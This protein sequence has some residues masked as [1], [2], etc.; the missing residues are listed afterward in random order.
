MDNNNVRIQKVISELGVMSRRKAEEAILNRRVTVNG[1][2][3]AIGMKVNPRKDIIAVDGENIS[4]GKK[5]TKYY[6]A[7]HKPRG[8]VTTLSDEMDRRCVAEL[9]ENA[10]AKVYPIGRLDRNTEGLLIFTNDGEFANMM[11]H[12]RYHVPKTYRVT[13]RPDVNDEQL[14]KLAQGVEIDGVM[15][16]PAEIKVLTKEPDRAVM[17]MSIT[18][19]RNRQIRKMCEAVGLEVA[20]LRRTAVGSVKLGMLKPGEWR[21]LTNEEVK[22]LRQMAVTASRRQSGKPSGAAEKREG[23]VIYEERPRSL[24]KDAPKP[25][26]AKEPRFPAKRHT[27]GF[28]WDDSRVSKKPGKRP[29]RGR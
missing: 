25:P 9:V 4:K 24:K 21:F 3:A 27:G 23:K 7:L 11:M 26:K 12:P 13:V 22:A 18:E 8:Y 5:I 6:L 15:T 29:P 14:L 2:P 1:R 19:G 10:P 28:E 16:L 20:R 17:Q